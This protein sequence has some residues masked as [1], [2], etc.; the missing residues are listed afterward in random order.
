MSERIK[1]GVIGCRVG[2]TWVA[3]AQ[4][5]E[6]T[7]AWAVADL[8]QDLARQVAEEHGVAKVYGDYRELLADS[9]VEAVGI[10]TAPDVRKPMVIEALEAGKHV[11][12]QKPHGR[13]AADVEEINA[14]AEASGKTLVYSY[15]MRHQEVNK[16]SQ[17]LVADGAIGRAYHARVHYHYRE[18][19]I[20][21]EPPPGR[22][23][24]YRWG[25]K[26]GALGQHGSHYLDQA[27]FLLGSPRPEWAFAIAHSAFPTTLEVE[28]HAEDYLSVLVGCAGGITIQMDTSALIATWED[29]AWD[30]RLRILG[31]NGTIEVESTS[32]PEG[33][34]HSGTRR[35]LGAIYTEGDEFIDQSVDHSDGDFDAE[36][37]DFAA[38]I[39]GAQR[40][41]VAPGDALEFMKLLDAI[42]LSAE[43]GEKVWVAR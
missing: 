8:N 32:L 23:W 20:G 10:A 1:V 35:L 28:R 14:V 2:R 39:R 30:L 5:G 29:R 26:G 13:N 18:R 3:G 4:A 36:I 7:S 12:V 40:P 22:D 34:R 37:A 38:A 17:Q 33:K 16:E 25:L 19:G 31:T 21:Y 24:L 27:W 42:Y 41:D 43:S 9:E 15:F 11:L 6:A